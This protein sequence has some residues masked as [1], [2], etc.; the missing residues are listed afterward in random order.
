MSKYTI[1][2]RKCCDLYGRDTVEEWFSSYNLEDFLTENQ[3]NIIQKAGLFTKEKLA[4]RIVNHFF[5]REI[6]YETT[7]LFR[8]QI[9]VK[10]EEIMEE[11]LPII[12]TASEEYDIFSDVDYTETYKMTGNDTSTATGG[13]TNTSNSTSN[14]N[15]LSILNDTPQGENKIGDTKSGKYASQINYNDSQISDNTSQ[16]TSSNSNQNIDRSEN[17][18]KHVQG[19][20]GISTTSQRMILEYRKTIR[21]ITKEIINLLEP[22]FISLFN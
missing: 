6:G 8:Q 5:M 1:Q 2:L 16:T 18:E 19:N 17:Y 11:Y 12:Y 14:N 21:A 13:G 22:E 3:I 10:M 4:K 20:A 7:G 15:S 9:L